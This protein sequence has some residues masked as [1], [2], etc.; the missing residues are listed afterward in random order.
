M[1]DI[2]EMDDSEIAYRTDSNNNTAKMIKK[3][4]RYLP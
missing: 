2:K 1:S 4:V 3:F